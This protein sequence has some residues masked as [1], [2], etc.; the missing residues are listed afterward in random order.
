MILREKRGLVLNA[1]QTSW[2]QCKAD[3]FEELVCWRS[4]ITEHRVSLRRVEMKVFW[5]TP[6]AKTYLKF[7][8]RPYKTQLHEISSTKTKTETIPKATLELVP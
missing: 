7:D 4:E 3:F 8:K 1:M 6:F 5:T 2:G